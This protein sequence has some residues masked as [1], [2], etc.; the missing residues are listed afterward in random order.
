MTERAPHVS[1]VMPV[2]NCA[3]FLPAAVESVLGQSYGDF[4]LIAVDDGSTDGSLGILRGYEGR[5][6]RVRILSR[7]NTGIVRALNDGL[8]IARGELI[9]RMDGDDIS[10]PGR[11]ERQVWFMEQNPDC[12]AAG[13]DAE[14]ID[15]EGLPFQRIKNP[16]G[17]EEIVAAL[18]EGN[19][20]AM[21]HP[22]CIFRREAIEKV[23]GY[24]RELSRWGEDLDLFLRLS[25][26]G[27]L[28]NQGEMLFQYRLRPGS[29]NTAGSLGQRKAIFEVV[30]AA[31]VRRGLA[32][33]AREAAGE[34]A[35]PLEGAG[36]DY[37]VFCRAYENGMTRTARRRAWLAV[38]KR[39]WYFVYWKALVQ[40]WLTHAR[41]KK[42][43]G[44]G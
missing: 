19:G 29:I 7:A 39:P 42:I 27:R 26:I 14:W 30:R 36:F 17:H 34:A 6:S 9:A 37:F 25:E 21:V 44:K 22:T 20:G 2:Y 12:V 1:V 28:A 33:G 43:K 31:R 8:A 24:S 23:G 5:D 13:T 15:T 10:L 41:V 40:A 35:V 3:E 11:L 18:L 4:E 32:V 16:R 38:R